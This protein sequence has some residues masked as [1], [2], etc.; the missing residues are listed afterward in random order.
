MSSS[1]KFEVVPVGNARSKSSDGDANRLEG[2]PGDDG[3]IAEACV[4][5]EIRGL[6]SGY[7]AWITEKNGMCH[8]IR[9]VGRG[10]SEWLGE[11]PNVDCALQ[12]LSDK[13]A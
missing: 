13:V 6:P 7:K 5:F 3:Q 8:L 1:T 2:V 11:Y 12:A 10:E 4:A 9:E